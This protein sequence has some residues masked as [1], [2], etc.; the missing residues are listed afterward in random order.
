MPGN[1]NL[2]HLA[3]NFIPIQYICNLIKYKNI[4][5]FKAV[6]DF[7]ITLSRYVPEYLNLGDQVDNMLC[8]MGL[9]ITQIFISLSKISIL[10]EK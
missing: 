6:K 2:Y 3:S 10:I 9:G 8:D 5:L 7:F 4:L 1:K